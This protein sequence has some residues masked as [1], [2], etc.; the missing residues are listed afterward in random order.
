MIHAFG[1]AAVV[2]VGTLAATEALCKL[3]PRVGLLAHPNARSSHARATP[4]GGG[5]GFVLPL[6]VCFACMAAEYPPAL[7]LLVAGFAIAA[8]GLVDDFVDVPRSVRLGCHFALAAGATLWLFAPGWL[9]GG[10]LILGLVWWLN[11][12]NFMDGIDGLAASQ[13]AGWA[14]GALALGDVGASAPPLWAL[15][16]ASA[17]FL[18]FNWAPARVFMG[19]AGAGFLGLA[20]GVAALWL[21]RSGE[22]PIVASAILLL[23]FWFD[24]TYTLIVRV[25]TGQAFADAHRTHLYQILARRFGHG[26]TTSLLWLHLL[27][28]L[29]P[30]AAVALAFPA[31]RVMCLLVAAAPMAALCVAC[32]AGVPSPPAEAD[33]R[34][35]ATG[36][37]AADG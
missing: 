3:A 31:W 7:P 35:G 11:L 37:G 13:A 18:C 12:Y 8:L 1:W 22:F 32:R 20:T 17:A 15:L 29:G 36:A 34:R 19:D 33:A 9:V 4:T 16:A 27:V 5:V 28:W 25:V 23:P 24:A 10:A 30:L 6:L 2:F 21:W 14:A 26:R